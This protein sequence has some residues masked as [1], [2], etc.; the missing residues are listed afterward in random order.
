MTK[1]K[2]AYY[3]SYALSKL[4]LGVLYGISDFV[5]VIMFYVCAIAGSW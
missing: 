4:P 3:I 5:F 1:Y 2:K